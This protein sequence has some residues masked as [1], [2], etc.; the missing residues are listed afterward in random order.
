MT[1]TFTIAG[2]IDQELMHEMSEFYNELTPEDKVYVFLCSDGGSSYSKEAIL[3]ILEI[4]K[5]NTTLIGYGCL[6]SA[7]FEL[8]MDYTGERQLTSTCCGMY[9]RAKT[10]IALSSNGRARAEEDIFGQK[11]IKRV[12]WAYAEALMS[13]LEMKP[14][15]RKKIASGRDV[16]FTH[17]EMKNFLEISKNSQKS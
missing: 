10:T 13:R 6:A 14:A 3:N 15:D 4:Y 17:E 9:H 11:E 5:D 8:F 2:D 7:A 16:Y 1:K 12:H